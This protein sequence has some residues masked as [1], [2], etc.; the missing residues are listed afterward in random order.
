MGRVRTPRAGVTTDIRPS[1]VRASV[2]TLRACG[3]ALLLAATASLA[4]A[5]ALWE[6]AVAMAAAT[7]H[8][9]PG[10]MVTHTQE[11][12]ADGK[13]R[14]T[15]ETVMRARVVGGELTYE[16]VRDVKDGEAVEHA[17]EAEADGSTGA[18][19]ARFSDAFQADL[20]AMVGAERMGERRTIRGQTAV[21]YR[22]EQP[23]ELYTIRGQL[24]VSEDGVPLELQYTVDPLP[25]SVRGI[26]ILAAYEQRDGLALVTEVTVQVA[27]SVTFLYRRLYTITVGLDDYFDPDA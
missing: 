18:S 16:L 17:E 27:V 14:S 26:A 1:A 3:T 13:L 4:G 20:S 9:V 23:E 10:T 5:D 7:G 12:S 22:I 8:L 2:R 25:R 6:R 24:W 19:S 15:R 21:G 11:H